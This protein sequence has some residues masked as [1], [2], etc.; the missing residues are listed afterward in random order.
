MVEVA[1]ED[2]VR[3]VALNVA[4]VAEVVGQDTAAAVVAD[5]QG[6]GVLDSAADVQDAAVGAA[7]DQGDVVEAAVVLVILT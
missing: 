6:I 1:D 4:A 3:A 2:D 5:D 7:V